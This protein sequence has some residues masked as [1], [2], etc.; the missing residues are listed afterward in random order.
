MISIVYLETRDLRRT[1]SVAKQVNIVHL[2][3]L[4]IRS[5]NNSDSKYESVVP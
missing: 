5:P 3:H 4:A 2:F 1:N